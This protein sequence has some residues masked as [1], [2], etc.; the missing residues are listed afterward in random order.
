M[1]F[2]PILIFFAAFAI[3]AVVLV[4]HE[5]ALNAAWTEAAQRLNLQ[6]VGVSKRMEGRHGGG[7]VQ[8]EGYSRGSGKSKRNYTDFRVLAPQPLNFS[9]ELAPQG[10][11]HSITSMLGAQDIITGDPVFDQAVV[12]RGQPEERVREWLT[13]ERRALIL[14]L[15]KGNW[16]VTSQAVLIT[17]DGFVKDFHDFQRGLAEVL[18][19]APVWGPPGEPQPSLRPSATPPPLPTRERVAPEP[20]P[21]PPTSATKA[22]PGPPVSA[23]VEAAYDPGDKGRVAL[24]TQLFA[25]DMPYFKAREAFQETFRER[26]AEWT[27]VIR[28]VSHYYADRVFGKGPGYI[29]VLAWPGPADDIQA[30]FQMSEA[31]GEAFRTREGQTARLRGRMVQCDPFLPGIF[32][33]DGSPA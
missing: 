5:K 12:V 10:W 26:E 31:D 7:Y 33:A 11:F 9:L 19:M 22:A 1:E 2:L 27:G 17:R 28:N 29:V 4:R 23:D 3:F 32:L 24:F 20:A 15:R 6:R 13:P 21:A 8:I 14:S 30:H 16:R 18:T 25:S